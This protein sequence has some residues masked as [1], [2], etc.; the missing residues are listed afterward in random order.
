MITCTA[1][2]AFTYFKPESCVFVISVDGN[3]HPSGM[4]AGWHMKCSWEPPLFAVS[5]S[6]K[7]YTH[8]LIQKSKEFTIA[9]PNKSLEAAVEFFGATHGNEV[10]K[11]AVTGI[12]TIPAQKIRPPLIRDATIN[13]EC[14]LQQEVPAGDHILFIGQVVAAYINPGRKILLN[15]GRQNGKRIFQEF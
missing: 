11:F 14:I 8:R 3:G 5:L 2:D 9:V 10:D 4:V 1:R 13:L 12:A 7:G 6:R 15:M